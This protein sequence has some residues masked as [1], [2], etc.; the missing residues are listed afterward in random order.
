MILPGFLA[1]GG[2]GDRDRD[3]HE[4]PWRGGRIT[5][6]S[7]QKY[8]PRPELRAIPELCGPSEDSGFH[9]QISVAV[10]HQAHREPEGESR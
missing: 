2:A 6:T 3:G 10:S 7:W 5:R 4:A 9:F 8:L 1:V